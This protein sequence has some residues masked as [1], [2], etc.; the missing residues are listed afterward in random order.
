MS[1]I[2]EELQNIII[3]EY[4]DNKIDIDKYIELIKKVE[5]L[6]EGKLK[7]LRK[8]LQFTK[9]IKGLKRLIQVKKDLASKLPEGIEKT[10][11]LNSIKSSEEKLL[12]LRKYRIAGYVGGSGAVLIASPGSEEGY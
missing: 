3:D 8:S 5:N 6:T 4:L 1:L 11:V 9:H 10:K 7:I 12:K 2:R